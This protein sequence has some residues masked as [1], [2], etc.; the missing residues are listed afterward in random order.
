MTDSLPRAFYNGAAQL[1][2]RP[3]EHP[4]QRL[5]E[6]DHA[7]MAAMTPSDLGYDEHAV[8]MAKQEARQR[9]PAVPRPINVGRIE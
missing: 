5:G 6:P 2:S 7:G 4:Q 8:A 3:D 9:P 1:R